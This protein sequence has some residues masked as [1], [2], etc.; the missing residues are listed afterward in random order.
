M[1]DN[2]YR[3]LPVLL[4]FPRHVHLSQQLCLCPLSFL[5]GKQYYPWFIVH[6]AIQVRLRYFNGTDST[7]HKREFVPYLCSLV[8][9]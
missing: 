1:I 5:L 6:Q 2:V 8:V 7:Y 9:N 3:A 4:E